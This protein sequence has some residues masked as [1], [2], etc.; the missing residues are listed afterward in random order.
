MMFLLVVQRPLQRLIVFVIDRKKNCTFFFFG[1]NALMDC[2][3]RNSA[4][5]QKYLN[6]SGM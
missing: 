3:M 4:G 2:G 6:M 1:K 5:L